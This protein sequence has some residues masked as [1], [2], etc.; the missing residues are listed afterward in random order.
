[1]PSIHGY[2]WDGQCNV[3]MDSLRYDMYEQKSI[4]PRFPHEARASLGCHAS[5]TNHIP[6]ES[7][8]VRSLCALKVS[9]LHLGGR[10]ELSVAGL[11]LSVCQKEM[12]TRSV[13]EETK[14]AY[15]P[16]GMDE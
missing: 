5:A 14:R 9:M 13:K 2:G 1:M 16:T 11:E 4:H 3:E 8:Q 12:R 10:P 6:H 7:V 15:V